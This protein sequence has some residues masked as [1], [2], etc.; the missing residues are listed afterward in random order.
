MTQEKT[1]V[2]QLI[3]GDRELDTDGFQQDLERVQDELDVF[4]G[5][6]QVTD[7]TDGRLNG[8]PVSVKDNICVDGFEATA[9][10]KILEGYEPGFTATVVRRLQDAGAQVVG[11]TNQDEFGFGTFSTNS[12]YGVPKNPHDRDRVAGGSSGGAAALTAALDRPHIA[13]GQST[14][15]SISCPAAFC[16]V[17][18][19]T[20][21]YG[22]NSRYGL[23]DYGNSLDKIGPIARSVGDAVMALDIMQG[24]DPQDFTTARDVPSVVPEEYSLEGKKIG[25]PEQY[26][27]YEGVDPA[28]RDEVRSTL[29]D[30]ESRG[31]VVESVD[32]PKI[33]HEFTVPSY[34]ITAVAEASTNLAR[35][36]G[37]R[38]GAEGDPRQQGF[39]E[40]FSEVRTGAFGEEARRRI[41]LGH[42]AR[43]AGY[44]D[45]YYVKALKVRRLVIEE[46]RRA[47]GEY[48][49][50]AS[51]TMPIPAPTFE[52]A[53]EL[54]PEQVYAMDTLTVGANLAGLPHVSLPTGT[55]D[56]M[57]VGLQLIG[58]HFD[59]ATMLSTAGAVE[60]DHGL[61]DTPDL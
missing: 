56:G 8:L 14:G 50:L 16:G 3:D 27:E 6:G 52:E 4:R 42:F 39:D 13:Y 9:G 38:Y 33:G 15:G 36:C 21:T 1:A 34:Y 29:D 60:R 17:V 57:P 28:V 32:L 44:R 23:I 10:S 41:M 58:D 18:G 53:G 59:E 49:V 40:Y 54:P 5:L 43:Q 20:P 30:L 47:L 45:A 24:P 25:V 11:K 22:R 12:A 46:F 61:I 55:V 51:P 7:D 37:M 35:F 26:M 19:V 48:D 2:Q 31:A